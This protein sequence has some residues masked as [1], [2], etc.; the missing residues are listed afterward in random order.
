MQTNNYSQ[1]IIVSS[2]DSRGKY[3][4]YSYP[5]LTIFHQIHD[6][7][8]TGAIILSQSDREETS[9]ESMITQFQRIQ[10]RNLT[11]GSSLVLHP[12]YTWYFYGYENEKNAYRKKFYLKFNM[13]K[14]NNSIIVEEFHL[15]WKL[16]LQYSSKYWQLVRFH[17]H[18]DEVTF[19]IHGIAKD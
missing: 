9:N 2:N 6:G 17:L 14:N 12:E 7:S 13:F 15:A 10:N 16:N 1:T 5:I 3:S 11:T 4:K 8:L 19:G 18:Q